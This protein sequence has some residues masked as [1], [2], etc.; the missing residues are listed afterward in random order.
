MPEVKK[1]KFLF[2]INPISGG[3]DKSAWETEIRT[4]FEQQP[5]SADLFLLDGKNDDIELPKR[6]ET[7]QPDRLVAV[8]GDGTIKFVA[9]HALN[10]KI[11]LGIIPAGSANGMARELDIP[12]TLEGSLEVLINGVEKPIDLICINGTEHCLHLSDIGMNAQLVKYFDEGKMRGKLGYARG[13]LR[14]LMRRRL[15]KLQINTGDS[16]VQRTAFMVVLANARMY[17]TGAIINPDGDV[18]DGKFEVVVIRKLS[19]VAILRM[20]IHFRPFDPKHIE[21]FSASSVHIVTKR[22]A[23]FQ[24]DGEYRGKIRELT[25]E[26]W[27]G[28]L[29]VVLPA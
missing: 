9:E 2:A 5:H 14:V 21:I 15:L 22:R 8:G 12:P 18:A 27:P 28:H 1:L 13:V 3:Q 23:Y 17:G 7:Y 24:I 16:V 19:L 20:F 25:A 10:A 26:I 4:F 29:Q 11:P 6:I